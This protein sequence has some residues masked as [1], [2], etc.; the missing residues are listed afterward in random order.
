MEAAEHEE[1]EGDVLMFTTVPLVHGY[2][3]MPVL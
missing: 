2:S 1:R 3:V